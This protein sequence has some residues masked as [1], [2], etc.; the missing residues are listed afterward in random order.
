MKFWE[1][2]IPLRHLSAGTEVFLTVWHLDSEK[3]GPTV[4]LQAALH[5]GEIQ[6]IGVIYALR[7]FLEK[8][9]FCGKFI[10][11]PLA[12]P[13]ALSLKLGEYTYGRFDATT[14]ENWNRVFWN[15]L[16]T[17][18]DC[19]IDL[20]HFL[21]KTKNLP[22]DVRYQEY[23]KALRSAIINKKEQC[24][25]SAS[26]AE[27]LALTLQEI[28]VSADIV[29]DLHCDSRAHPYLFS[30]RYSMQEACYLL[31][32]FQIITERIFTP[33][34][35]QAC[36]IPWWELAETMQ[37]N[38]NPPF[39]SVTLELGS[40]DV[41]SH[42]F[43]EET[44]HRIINFLRY[45]NIVEGKPVAPCDP[46][47]QCKVTDFKR[48]RAPKGGLVD[49]IAPLGDVLPS[50]TP[51]AFFLSLGSGLKDLAPLPLSLPYDTIP[52][53]HASSS[54]VHARDE[55]IKVMTHYTSVDIML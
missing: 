53:T 45:K 18:D 37:G 12:N 4:Y 16:S 41:Y 13:F 47:T 36:F 43:S 54:N 49:V 29:F 39:F 42:T 40:K 38:S 8:N 26:F 28:A 15:P 3:P 17:N 14:G 44:A 2:K 1:E 23:K 46:V 31:F 22:R 9:P 52:L 30:P 11:V 5:A 48:I 35:N 27:F 34:F 55:I 20:T 25:E 10:F 24:K 33:D 7:S 19:A 21:S 51:Y 32:K 6:G 50:H